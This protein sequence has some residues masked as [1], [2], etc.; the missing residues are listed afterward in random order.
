MYVCMYVCL[1][2]CMY[3]CTRV[4][5]YVY[6]CMCRCGFVDVFCVYALCVTSEDLDI[7]KRSQKKSQS[8][9]ELWNP[10]ILDF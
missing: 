2:V 3:V 9:K 5:M 10:Y 8:M 4:Y 1:Y 7:C 6:V